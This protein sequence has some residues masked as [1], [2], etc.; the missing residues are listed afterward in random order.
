[1]PTHLHRN[2][3]R[4]VSAVPYVGG[5]AEIVYSGYRHHRTARLLDFLRPIADHM[6]D[7]SGLDTRLAESDQL[8]AVFGRAVRV[9]QETGL[10][11]KRAALGRVIATAVLDDAA[12]DRA[13][14]LVDTLDQ[15]E[16]PHI[17][18]LVRVRN[19]AEDAAVAGELPDRAQ[20]A[21]RPIV[22]RIKQAGAELDEVVVR[23]TK[24]LGLLVADEG[25]DEWT[26]HG[27][28]PYGHE[29]LSFLDAPNGDTN[30]DEPET[31]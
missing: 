1:M 3:D 9:A 22:Q 14:L 30:T 10:A 6:N 27:L 21:E 20:H 15:V 28:T 17:H 16:A 4:L 18:A 19:A 23:T 5:P 25:I 8:E 13:G 24:N 29:L 12:V 26:V 31:T 2:L 7:A 11:D